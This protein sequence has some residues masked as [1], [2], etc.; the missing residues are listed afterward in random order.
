MSGAWSGPSCCCALI[1]TSFARS[2]TA[3]LDPGCLSKV[4]KVRSCSSL[5]GAR[6]FYLELKTKTLMQYCRMGGCLVN[7]NFC[8][9]LSLRCV[10]KAVRSFYLLRRQFAFSLSLSPFCPPLSLFLVSFFFL[11]SFTVR[12]FSDTTSAVPPAFTSNSSI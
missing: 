10:T 8:Y 5:L 3:H 1:P 9:P 4:H 2:F 7:N 6:S 12:L 11:H